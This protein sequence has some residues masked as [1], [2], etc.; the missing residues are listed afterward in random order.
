MLRDQWAKKEVTTTL[1]VIDPDHQEAGQLSHNRG[2]REHAH[3][4][5]DTLGFL[6]VVLYPIQMEKSQV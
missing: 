5:G 2:R 3:N 1:E 6:L 4:P